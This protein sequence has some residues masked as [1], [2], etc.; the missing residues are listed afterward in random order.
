MSRHLEKAHQCSQ[1]AKI[2]CPV[3]ARALLRPRCG[4]P[5][6]TV[7]TCMKVRPL[8]SAAAMEAWTQK[9]VRLIH[10]HNWILVWFVLPLIPKFSSSVKTVCSGVKLLQIVTN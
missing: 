4:H 6:C 10:S 7:I 8:H 5:G 3:R 9:R 2:P 1:D